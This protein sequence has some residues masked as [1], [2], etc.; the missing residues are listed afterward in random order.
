MH[1]AYYTR[2]GLIELY[3]FV[4]IAGIRK[5][6]LF[7]CSVIY[8]FHLHLKHPLCSSLW[9]QTKRYDCYCP[10][11]GTTKVLLF[12]QYLP[13]SPHVCMEFMESDLQPSVNQLRNV[14]LTAS[15][16][17]VQPPRAP[18]TLCSDLCHPVL[19][20]AAVACLPKPHSCLWPGPFPKDL[21]LAKV[22]LMRPTTSS[23]I[24]QHRTMT[25]LVSCKLERKT[26][27]LSMSPSDG[28]E[29]GAGCPTAWLL[30]F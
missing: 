18:A 17:L 13:W 29:W 12:M 5:K 25:A 16:L 3:V 23:A 10:S 21:C 15:S 28:R 20:A 7:H 26:F 9:I 4:Y 2:P 8:R 6:L 30:D 27:T 14:D 22:Q 19:F 24:S 11:L 1:H